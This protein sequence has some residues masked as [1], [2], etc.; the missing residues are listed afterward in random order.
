MSIFPCHISIEFLNI[1]VALFSDNVSHVLSYSSSIILISSICD[2]SMVRNSFSFSRLMSES[3]RRLA[4]SMTNVS[5][6]LR[7]GFE[8]FVVV[9]VTDVI[10]D[11]YFVLFRV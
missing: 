11:V 2:S 1:D 8:A 7:T 5:L 10:I 9:F 3:V 4:F 6:A